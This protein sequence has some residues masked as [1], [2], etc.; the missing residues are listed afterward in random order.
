MSTTFVRGENPLKADKLNTAFS[1]RVSR[2]GDTMQGFLKL[3]ADPV[4]AFDAATKQYVDRFTSMGVPTGAYIGSAPPGNVLG[5]LWWDTNSGQLFIQYNDG[6]STQWVSANSVTADQLLAS[7]LFLPLTGGTVSGPTTHQSTMR[8]DYN[9]T[10]S[11]DQTAAANHPLQVAGSYIG[12]TSANTDQFSINSIRNVYQAFQTG[13]GAFGTLI[14]GEIAAGSWMRSNVPLYVSANQVGQPQVP[15]AWATGQSITAAGTLRVNAG[16]FYQAT[17]TG[18]TGATAPVHGSG[19]LS[20]GG[21]SWLF[22]DVHSGSHSQTA[23]GTLATCN[24]NVGGAA[25]APVGV[26]YG[27]VLGAGLQNGATFYSENIVLELDDFVNPGASTT[28]AATAQLVKIAGQGSFQDWGISL[29]ASGTAR[30]RNPIIFQ[31]AVDPNGYAI[32]FQDQNLAGLQTMAGAIDMQMV[33]PTGNGKFGGG[34]F[35]RWPSGGM[36]DQSSNLRLGYATLNQNAN[37]LTIDVTQRKC[38]AVASIASGGSGWSTGMW[39]GDQNGNYVTVTAAAGVV[40][41]AALQI[42]GFSTVAPS[43]AQTFSPVGPNGNT[44]TATGG[45]SIPT[46][47]TA[48]LTYA[49]AATPAIAIASSG[50]ATSFGGSTTFNGNVAVAA[51]FNLFLAGTTGGGPTTLNG[52]FNGAGTFA[53]HGD[54]NWGCILQGL[55][56]G[57]AHIALQGADGSAPFRLV[58]NTIALSGTVGFNGTAPITKPA[59]WGAPTGTATRATFLTSSVTL[60]QLA[61]HVKALIDDLTAYGLIGL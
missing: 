38:T 34:F 17:T 58:N 46:T 12:G 23:L 49:A 21:V 40:T 26:N 60:P 54:A 5:P 51:G 36:I 52:M 37:G 14:T 61:E 48:N 33:T 41:A 6:S 9:W 4:Q 57:V 7:N 24:Y 28:R 42:A 13:Q 16:R 11:G 44:L 43:G 50:A 55:S 2:G 18:T 35:M 32:A 20:D 25:G 29:S 8:L 45:A 1:E 15:I 56:G 19:T 10:Y 22:C 31:S 53:M 30:W 27:A 47:F 59:G 3:A 39:A